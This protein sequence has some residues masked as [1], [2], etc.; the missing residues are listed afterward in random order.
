[1]D[2]GDFTLK[3]FPR[4]ETDWTFEYPHDRMLPLEGIISDAL[5]RSPDMW[6]ADKELCLLVVKAGN[7]TKTTIGRA[8]GVFSIVR[9]YF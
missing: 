3:C 8:N 2:P 7:T 4:D 6:D 5:M 9:D 1:M